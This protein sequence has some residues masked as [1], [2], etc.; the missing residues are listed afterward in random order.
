MMASCSEE[1]AA[2]SLNS[3]DNK[4]S[5]CLAA[6]GLT[7]CLSKCILDIT[8]VSH[9]GYNENCADSKITDAAFLQACP[10]SGIPTEK[11]VAAHITG[12]SLPECTGLTMDQTAS[13]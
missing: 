10:E 6:K 12:N 3:S 5:C 4:G 2:G 7:T 11:E 8:A 13:N 9:S 1:A